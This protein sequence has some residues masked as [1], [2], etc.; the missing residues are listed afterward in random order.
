[1]DFNFM[2]IRELHTKGTE[3]LGNEGE[4]ALGV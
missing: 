2:K 3:E 4:R 1:M